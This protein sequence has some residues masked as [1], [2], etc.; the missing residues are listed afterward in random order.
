MEQRI[1]P[2]AVPLLIVEH[3]GVLT[4]ALKLVKF[5]LDL[6]TPLDLLLDA[7]NIGMDK[8]VVLLCVLGDLLDHLLCVKGFLNALEHLL[9]VVAEAAAEE[10]VVVVSDHDLAVAVKQQVKL[11]ALVAHAVNPLAFLHVG[12]SGRGYDL[13]HGILIKLFGFEEFH[14]LYIELQFVQIALGA[15]SSG[16][17]QSS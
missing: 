8:I 11:V 1:V 13:M 4:L 2:K 9:E 5:D 3:L 6:L 7:F 12:P 10:Q 16:L 14:L 15:V 17:G